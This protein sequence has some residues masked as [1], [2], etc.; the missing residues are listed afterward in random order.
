[1]IGISINKLFFKSFSIDPNSGHSIYVFDSTY[2]PDP[3]E[4]GDDKQVYDMLID[5]LMG[6][7][8]AKLPSS[9]FSLVI[10]SSGFTPEEN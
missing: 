8:I 10:F 1:M 7:L 9:P 4:L 3:T 6:M 5:E 2:L